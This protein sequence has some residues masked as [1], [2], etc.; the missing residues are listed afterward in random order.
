MEYDEFIEKFK[1]QKNHVDNNASFNGMM[2]ETYGAEFEFIKSQPES[3]VWTILDGDN[4]QLVV[5]SGFH[6]VNRIGYIVTEVPVPEGE[7]I[8]VID[9]D[10][11]D[12]DSDEEDA[13]PPQLRG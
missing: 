13:T 2:Y 1:P 4:G 6:H 3:N 10:D 12:L 11:I 9:E 8:E 7:F 5:A